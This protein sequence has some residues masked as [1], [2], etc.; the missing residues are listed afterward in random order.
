MNSDYLVGKVIGNRYEVTEKIGTGGMASVYKAKCRVLNRYVAIKVLKDSL[1]FDAEVVKKFNTESRAAARLSH[2]NIVQVYDVGENGDLDYIVMELVDGITLKEY[3]QRE[4][5]LPWKK[6]CDFAAQI[7]RALE[8]AH[9]HNIVHRDIKPHNVLM[10]KDGTL[11]VADFG[12]AQATSSETL[13][14]GS[15]A[16]GSVHYI[17][18]EQARG[19]FT[20]ERSDIYSLGVVLYEMLTGTLPF[21]GANPVAIAITKLE[22]EPED[23]RRINPEIPD[24]VAEIVMKA[25][26]REQHLR[27]QTA[28]EMV[29]D[30]EKAMGATKP[31]AADAEKRFETRR[32][33]ESAVKDEYAARRAAIQQRRKKAKNKRMALLA[34]LAIALIG[35]FT[36]L[37]MSGGTREYIV[38]DLRNMTLEEA[39]EALLGAELRLN[40]KIS[41]EPSDE[42][43]E[44]LV[45]KQNPGYNQYVKKNRKV[46]ITL[47]TGA[48]EGDIKIADVENLKYEDAKKR[49]EAQGL[50]CEKV[51]EFSETIQ[52]GYVIKQSPEGGKKAEK[53]DTVKVYVSSEEKNDTEQAVVPKVTGQKESEAKALITA[54]GLEVG[55]VDTQDNEAETGTVIGQTPAAKTGVEKGTKVNITVSKGKAVPTPTPV[56]TVAP[57]MKKKTL[58]V[59]I[60]DDAA[61]TV[62]IKVV[63]NGKTIH[64]KEHAKSEGT[65]DI[66]VQASKDA[67]VQ[68]YIDGVLAV[69]RVVSF[70]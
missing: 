57:E 66:V 26:S 3:I 35:I 58:T 7:G 5:K 28:A 8:C 42:V 51:E 19:G 27:Y 60:P 12:I 50:K 45:I 49:L 41:Y 39:E 17:S 23:L 65:V 68:A 32:I 36:F 43:E 40:D 4:G 64:D 22:R 61:E 55:N 54:A 38:P 29:S 46:T 47:S 44:G 67:S 6:A 13:V 33:E 48:D 16:M 21:D 15:G 31:A 30:L 10:A 25:I 9:A 56:Q 24:E 63:A 59:T 20:N 52:F 69:D 1:K 62:H 37:F 2:P 70:D 18:P 34:V 11:K 14:A 53:G